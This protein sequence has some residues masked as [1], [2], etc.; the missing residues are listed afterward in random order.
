MINPRFARFRGYVGVCETVNFFRAL[1][2]GMSAAVAI[3]LAEPVRHFALIARYIPTRDMRF[4]VER[5]NEVYTK[6]VTRFLFFM[7]W[8]V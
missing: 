8:R 4:S 7:T 5:C 3:P 1:E 6:F 2:L